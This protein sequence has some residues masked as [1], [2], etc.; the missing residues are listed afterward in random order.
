MTSLLFPRNLSAILGMLAALLNACVR[1]ALIPLFATPVFDR[2]L[3]GRDLSAWPELLGVGAGVAL[4]GALALFAQDALLGR[5][6]AH[7]AARWREG[8]YGALL[9][10][11]PGQL[12]GTSGGLASRILTDL[13][14]IETYYQFGLGT[15][16]AE[17]FTLLGV[18]LVLFFYNAQATLVLLGLGLPLVV[19]LAFLGRGLERAATRAQAGTEAVGAHLQ[20]GLKHHLVVRAFAALPFMAGRFAEAN[21]RTRR[22]SVRRSLFA[23]F[24]TPISQVLV[25]AAVAV[26]VAFLAN[27]LARGQMTT[28]EVISYL[29]LVL[30]LSTPAQ[31]LPKG[32]ALLQQA[33]AARTRLRDLLS[34][35]EGFAPDAASGS[36]GAGWGLELRGVGFA[37]LPGLPVLQEVSLRLPERGLVALV[38]ESGSGKT[39]LLQLV[40]RFLAPS[41]GKLYLRGDDLWTL[42]EAE[43]RRRVGYVPQGT[44]LLRGSLR[45]NLLLGRD[46]P[47]ERLWQALSAVGL[48][49]TMRT[50]GLDYSVREDGLGL[51]GGQKGRLAVARALLSEPEVLILDEPSA[52]LDEESERLLVATLRGEAE[53]RLVL[54]VAHRP[55]LVEAADRV[56]VLEGGRL[57]PR[58][59]LSR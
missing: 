45:D 56:L 35:P 29:V 27:S 7:V 40:L 25:F 44:D 10:R 41:E 42:S 5:T 30:L 3:A 51:S 59:A 57:E 55:A 16:V 37:Y 32:L 34:A 58:K 28:G 11:Q 22:S 9:G 47:D 46:Y 8:L 15:L 49:P 12:P 54:V 4:L 13:K 48:E 26:L 18:V 50:L 14:D 19:I 39:T 36:S 21:R 24:Q 43:L 20:E 1:V 6:A 53:R 2:V 52:N 17:S 23:A 33:F 38:G 31:L